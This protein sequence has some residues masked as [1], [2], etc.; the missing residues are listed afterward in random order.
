MITAPPAGATASNALSG[1]QAGPVST[2]ARAIILMSPGEDA[3][4][5]KYRRTRL[6]VLTLDY[7]RK[8]V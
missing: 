5:G 2:D 4:A 8:C 1:R 7:S 3:Q 6:F